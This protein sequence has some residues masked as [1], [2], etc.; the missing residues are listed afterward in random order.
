MAENVSCLLT[1][2]GNRTALRVTGK[3]LSLS[4][5]GWVFLTGLISSG[6]FLL[7]VA[8]GVRVCACA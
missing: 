8:L 2:Y 1:R 3:K 7:G 5:A 6:T 4:S